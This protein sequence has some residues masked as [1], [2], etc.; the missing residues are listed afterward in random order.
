MVKTLPF[1]K[2]HGATGEIVELLLWQYFFIL[3]NVFLGVGMLPGC[4]G[5]FP[6]KDLEI[7]ML[8]GLTPSSLTGGSLLKT[9]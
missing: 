2:L 5:T 1:D 4:A 6:R 9:N 8:A 3:A 7:Q